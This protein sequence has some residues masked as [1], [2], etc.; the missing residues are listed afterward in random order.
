MELSETL[1]ER[2]TRAGPRCTRLYEEFLTSTRS[3]SRRGLRETKVG[4][5]FR[6]VSGRAYVRRV[7]QRVGI[8]L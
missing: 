1:R 7:L 6:G 5:E 2:Q 4:Q 8:G 3:F